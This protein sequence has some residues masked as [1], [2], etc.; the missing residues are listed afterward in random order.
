[1]LVDYEYLKVGLKLLFEGI[2]QVKESDDVLRVR[3]LETEASWDLYIEEIDE[4][5]I[6]HVINIIDCVEDSLA[7]DDGLLP[8][9]VLKIFVAHQLFH[10]QDIRIIPLTGPNGSGSI[11]I[12]LPFYPKPDVNNSVA[13]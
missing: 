3:S 4:S 6:K 5:V 2:F 1:V 7:R 10:L 11:Q 12:V 13:K 8:E 9:S